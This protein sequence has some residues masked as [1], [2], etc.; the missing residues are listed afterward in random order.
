MRRAQGYNYEPVPQ[1]GNTDELEAENERMANDLKDKIGALKSLTID[2]G[3]EVRY[4]DK[5]LNELDDDM[6]RTSGFMG[7]T[8]SRVTRLAKQGRGYT[9]YMII[10]ALV[11]FLLLYFVLKLK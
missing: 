8:I 2:I 5:I 6:G 9:C 4:Q 3:H 7:N 11:V 1:N 10:F